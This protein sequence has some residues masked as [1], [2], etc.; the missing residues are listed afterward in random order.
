MKKIKL[1]K[2]QRDVLIHLVENDTFLH[3][4]PYMGQFRPNAYWFANSTMKRFRWDTVRKLIELRLIK[5]DKSIFADGLGYITQAG[6]D[7]L[8]D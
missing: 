8:N 6:K 2:A 4:M 5:H 3:Y 1:S 7:I